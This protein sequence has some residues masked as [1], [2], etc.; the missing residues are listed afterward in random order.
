MSQLSA[1]PS[2]LS[3]TQ[4]DWG[5]QGRTA[6]I[7]NRTKHLLASG[8]HSDIQ[9]VVGRYRGTIQTFRAHKFVLRIGSQVFD[10]LFYGEPPSPSHT[11]LE[12]PDATPEAFHNLLS[13]LYTDSVENLTSQ[14]VFDTLS[15]ASKYKIQLLFDLCSDFIIASLNMDNCLTML[16]KAE[17]LNAQ[18]VIGKCLEMLDASSGEILQSDS[19]LTVK[20]TT[21]ETVLQ[22]STLTADEYSVYKAAERWANHACQMDKMAPSSHNRRLKLGT[23]LSLIRFPLMTDVQLADGPGETGLLTKDELCDIFRY[24]HAT[25]KRCIPFRTTPRAAQT[26]RMAPYRAP[27]FSTRLSRT[28]PYT[29]RYSP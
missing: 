27:Q 13:Y 1:S 10:Q 3:L 4:S 22:R 25:A 7:A 6:G 29:P 5:W 2:A 28:Q 26:R 18:R 12:V 15:C 20:K 8:E 23:A 16:E 11:N 21:L 19:F 14:N 17:E 9:F 24:K